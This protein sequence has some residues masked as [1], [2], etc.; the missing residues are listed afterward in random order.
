MKK[1]LYM[2]LLVS[3]LLIV[4]N[5][6]F[7]QTPFDDI[8][9]HP[10]S[11]DIEAVYKKGIMI[12]TAAGKFSPE[13]FVDRAQLVVCLVRTFD[14]NLDGLEFVKEPV[15]SDIFDDVESDLWYS[16]VSMVAW[17]NNIFHISDRKFKPF[18]PVSRIEVASAVAN[19]FAAKKLSVVTTEMWPNYLDLT[20][21]TEEQQS[22]VSFVFNTSIMRYAGSEFKPDEKITRAELAAILNRT[23]NTLALAMPVQGDP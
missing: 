2:F 22:A 18:Q 16:D 8:Q 7:A 20:T 15:P 11:A 9:S 14:L 1:A 17:Y 3:M 10:A 6:G 19:S 13:A 12:G 5:A 21:L 4:P 23:L